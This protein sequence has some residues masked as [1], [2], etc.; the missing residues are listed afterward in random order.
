[1][2]KIWS[3]VPELLNAK[4]DLLADWLTISCKVAL[5]D[6]RWNPIHGINVT[7]DILVL[8]Y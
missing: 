6:I 3:W 7:V 1:M 8:T 5:T 2:T 4:V